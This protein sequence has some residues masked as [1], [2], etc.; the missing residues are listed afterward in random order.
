MQMPKSAKR[1]LRE[2]KRAQEGKEDTAK[3]EEDSDDED[4]D[5]ERMTVRCAFPR[6]C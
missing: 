1:R 5:I 3:A 6:H 4:D 2:I